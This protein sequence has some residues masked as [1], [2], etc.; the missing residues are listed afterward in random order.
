MTTRFA[1]LV[2]ALLVLAGCASTTTT[3]TADSEPDGTRIEQVVDLCGSEFSVAGVRVGD[4]GTSL[5]IDGEGEESRGASIDMTVCIL[6]GMGVPDS[7]LTRMDHTRALDG[8]QEGV[9]EDWQASWTYHPNN[10]L[11]IIIEE[12]P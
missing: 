5:F 12:R 7:V 11:D 9:W 1:A 4:A 3:A 6:L 8:M 2:A 10:G